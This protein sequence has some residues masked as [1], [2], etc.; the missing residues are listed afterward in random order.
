[1][2]NKHIA[3]FWFGFLV[4]AFAAAWLY[5]LWRRNR[6]VMPGPVILGKRSAT[7]K[8]VQG[9]AETVKPP[10]V[11]SIKIKEKTTTRAV[12]KDKLEVI[13]GIG[14]AS[15][16]RFNDAGVFTYAQLAAL[17]PEQIQQITS[18]SRWDPA[19]W[20]NEARRLSTEA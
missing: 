13:G 16:R 9:E 6:E 20:I 14:P 18:T 3:N 4:S 11:T 8:A 7:L 12:K 2:K 17:S 15:A 1:M 19:D 5:W 10:A